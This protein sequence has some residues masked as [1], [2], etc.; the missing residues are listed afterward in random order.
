M[1]DMEGIQI[2]II[3]L[4]TILLLANLF[5]QSVG[6]HLLTS[7]QADDGNDAQLIYITNLCV[8]ELII[9]VIWIVKGTF[10]VI[11]FSLF[12]TVS[13][14]ITKINEYVAIVT[15]AILWFNI[16]MSMHYIIIDKLLQV[17][18][19]IKYP[20]HCNVK[21]ARSVVTATWVA[22][23]FACACIAIPY[24]IVEVNYEEI[25]SMFYISFGVVFMI[26]G[27][28][29]YSFIFYRYIQARFDPCQRRILSFRRQSLFH[30]FKHSRFAISVLL[31]TSFVLFVIIPDVLIGFA[32][33]VK[34]R[35]NGMLDI[36]FVLLLALHQFSFI[37]DGYIYIFMQPEVRRL[38][39]R[40][41]RA[42][43]SLLSA[44][45]S[46]MFMVVNPS[47]NGAVVET[48]QNKGLHYAGCGNNV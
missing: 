40:K 20:T 11:S 10:S 38:F 39:S 48:R 2:A 5:I 28:G 18:L 16:Y 47:E 21:N 27:I 15:C 12:G 4:F 31:M 33:I 36:H 35:D 23:I 41:L 7:V 44:T 46:L 24:E 29:A 45:R 32:G 8:V 30:V 25:N 19:N 26:F 3:V 9:T 42:T 13:A 14:T 37:C 6:L 17:I 22:G 34:T 1:N 43:R